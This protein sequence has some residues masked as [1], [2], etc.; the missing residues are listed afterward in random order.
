MML[1][2]LQPF[3]F[4]SRYTFDKQGFYEAYER[5]PEKFREYVVKT[6]ESTYLN[7]KLAFRRRLY[8]IK[9]D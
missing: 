3:D 6:L 8:G 2:Q 4:I 7:D 1:S 9:E 5:Y